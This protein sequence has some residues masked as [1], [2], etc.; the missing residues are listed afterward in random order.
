MASNMSMREVSYRKTS[1]CSGDVLTSF[2][3][4]LRLGTLG[5][6]VASLCDPLQTITSG[7]TSDLLPLSAGVFFPEFVR[8][9]LRTFFLFLLDGGVG[10]P[11]DNGITGLH[12]EPLHFGTAPREGVV[13]T[14]ASLVCMAKGVLSDSNLVCSSSC[15]FSSSLASCSSSSCCRRSFSTSSSIF[16][17]INSCFL[18][19]DTFARGA[20]PLPK[21]EVVE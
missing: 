14:A 9:G 19:S 20:T 15:C 1:L 7:G 3:S 8:L 21:P 17:N 11:M 6:V 5:G 12:K 13:V 10:S 2:I 16:C 4:V 18:C